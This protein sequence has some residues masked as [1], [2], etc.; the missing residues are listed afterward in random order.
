MMIVPVKFYHSPSHSSGAVK[1][2]P[3]TLEYA[4]ACAMGIVAA[5]WTIERIAGF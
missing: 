3:R 4:S 1:L 5:F 2:A